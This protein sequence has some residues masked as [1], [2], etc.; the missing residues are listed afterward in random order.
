MAG[1]WCALRQ[2]D[3]IASR[4]GAMMGTPRLPAFDS[5]QITVYPGRS[6]R[7]PVGAAYVPSAMQIDRGH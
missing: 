6:F 7:K 2:K 5:L 1:T 4:Y 3:H